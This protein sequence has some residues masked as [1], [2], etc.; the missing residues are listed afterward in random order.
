M[1]QFVSATLFSMRQRPERAMIW[2][3]S[4]LHVMQSPLREEIQMYRQ[5]RRREPI[6]AAESNIF[7]SNLH[8]QFIPE[9]P[10][11]SSVRHVSQQSQLVICADG[12]IYWRRV[13]K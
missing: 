12:F 7:A 10:V 3:E 5:N 1:I 11:V 8:A 13:G 2:T 6:A 4:R 9:L